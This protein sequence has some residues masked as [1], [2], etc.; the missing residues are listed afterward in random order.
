MVMLLLCRHAGRQR[1][2][3]PANR[4]ALVQKGQTATAGELVTMSKSPITSTW[5]L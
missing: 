3:V 4:G 2:P 5:K 1:A